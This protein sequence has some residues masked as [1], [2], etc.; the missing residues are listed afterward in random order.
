MPFDAFLIANADA[1]D[2]AA[3][4]S[5]IASD[6]FQTMRGLRQAADMILEAAEMIATG[7]TDDQD[8]QRDLRLKLGAD[9]LRQVMDQMPCRTPAEAH[10]AP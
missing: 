7:Q 2:D 10:T 8:H 4:R 9:K 1:L 3:V 6:W 5:R